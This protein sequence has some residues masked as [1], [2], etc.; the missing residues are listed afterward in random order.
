[1]NDYKEKAPW[2]Q[3]R[4]RQTEIANP[5]AD[6]QAPKTKINNTTKPTQLN[7]TRPHNKKRIKTSSNT[8]IWKKDGRQNSVPARTQRKEV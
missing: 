4:A 2:P 3:V 7:S 8:K 1:M 6:S 5:Q